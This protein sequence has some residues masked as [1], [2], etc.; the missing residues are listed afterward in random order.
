MNTL[1]FH[2]FILKGGIILEYP[3]HHL[4][5]GLGFKVKVKG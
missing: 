4:I 3:M 1:L 5:L 2:F